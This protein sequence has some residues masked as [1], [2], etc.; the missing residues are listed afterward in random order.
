MMETE[1]SGRSER[2]RAKA[3]LGGLVLGLCALAAADPVVAFEARLSASSAVDGSVVL[4]KVRAPKGSAG[5]VSGVFEG[6]E[7]PFFPVPEEGEDAWG[8][9]LGIPFNHAPGPTTVLVRAGEGGAA[10]ERSLTLSITDGQ[11]PAESLKVDA[12]FE[13]IRRKDLARINREKAEIGALYHLVSPK[14]RW[15]GPFVLPIASE[16][17]SRFGTKRVFN[18]QMKSFHQ[19]L[20]LKAPIGTPVR[21]PAGGKV[22]LAKDLFFTGNTVI[23]DHGYGVF[24]IYAH[25]SQLKVKKGEAVLVNG[26]LGLS[27]KTGRAS[28]PHLHWGAVIHKSKVNPAD[29]TK[30]MQ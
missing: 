30:V 6:K 8:A 22:V 20:D 15:S 26:T 4:V 12:K 1:E 11:Y 28:G 9:V 24:T 18:G 3:A 23:L 13:N 14:K 25:M 19:G 5:P 29:L 16:I 17:T 7:I 10:L 21:A 27:G 2:R